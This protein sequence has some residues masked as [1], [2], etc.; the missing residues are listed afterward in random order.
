MTDL[1]LLRGGG[2][3]EPDQRLAVDVS[4]RIGKSARTALTSKTSCSS[5]NCGT[6]SAG[7]S[8]SPDRSGNSSSPRHPPAPPSGLRPAQSPIVGAPGSQPG[9]EPRGA[10]GNVGVDPA[11]TPGIVGTMPEVGTAYGSSALSTVYAADGAEAASGTLPR[12]ATGTVCGM[13]SGSGEV[14][15]GTYT[16]VSGITGAAGVNGLAAP[17]AAV[18]AERRRRCV[19]RRCPAARRAP[20]AAGCPARGGC[21]RRTTG[22]PAPRVRLR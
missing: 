7:T 21:W 10:T 16:S 4:R 13:P 18:P 2:V 20:P 9:T 22:T 3:V 15:A 1:R 17:A 19:G 11:S 5:G 14:G 12:G 8:R 6:G